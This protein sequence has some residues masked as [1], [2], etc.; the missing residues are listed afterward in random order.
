MPPPLSEELSIEEWGPILFLFIIITHLEILV[1][2]TDATS[3]TDIFL[4]YI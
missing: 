1:I 4:L 3:R 2:I